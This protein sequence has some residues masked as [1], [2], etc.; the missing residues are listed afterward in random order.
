M[1]GR[2]RVAASSGSLGRQLCAHASRTH[3]SQLASQRDH[4]VHQRVWVR[5]FNSYTVIQRPHS[6]LRCVIAPLAWRS[7]TQL[8][9][10]ERAIPIQL[11]GV[12]SA[13]GERSR[14]YATSFALARLHA[15]SSEQHRAIIV[16]GVACNACDAP[17]EPA[18]APAARAPAHRAPWAPRARRSAWH[19]WACLLAPRQQSPARR[20]QPT[21]PLHPPQGLSPAHPRSWP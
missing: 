18:S 19:A 17:A 1:G 4:A 15:V 12:K 21:G 8:V 9:Y 2:R 11:C 5:S 6:S 13:T 14:A 3:T 16:A 10:R 7:S 20:R